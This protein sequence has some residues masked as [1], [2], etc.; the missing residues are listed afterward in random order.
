MMRGLGGARRPI[1]NTGQ[2]IAR[3]Y[4]PVS[5]NAMHGKFELMIKVYPDGNLTSYLDKLKVG[6][7]V[8][9]S[10]TSANVKI[11]YPF[12]KPEIG[13]L[14]GGTCITPMIQALHA[15]LGTP[16]DDTKVTMLYASKTVDDILARDVL[17]AWTSMYPLRLRVVHVLSQEPES[18]SWQGYRGHINRTLI[19][20]YFPPPMTESIIF[21]CGPESHTHAPGFYDTF[22]G[23]RQ[24]KNAIKG[25]LGDMGYTNDQVYKF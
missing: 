15:I 19:E 6:D 22:S 8:E 1:D 11:Q 14:I 10:H 24:D 21:V 25:L 16:G 12:S 2:P 13:M 18:S 5:T 9:F 20:E 7:F 23:P 3:P 4:T 17:D